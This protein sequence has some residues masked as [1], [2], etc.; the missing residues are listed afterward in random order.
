M[1]KFS[2]SPDFI[3]EAGQRLKAARLALGLSSKD[4]CEAINVQPNTYS[5]WEHGKAMIDPAA[6]TRLKIQFGVSL[7]WIYAGDPAG[8]PYSIASKALKDAS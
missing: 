3:L 1:P 7:D 5:Q 8:L 4:V 2:R 6:A